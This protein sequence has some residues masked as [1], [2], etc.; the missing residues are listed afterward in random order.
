MS[1]LLTQL[2][3]GPVT[4]TY[5]GTGGLV[6]GGTAAVSKSK[7][8]L[9]TGGLVLGGAAALA[10]TKTITA[11]GGLVFNS[12]AATEYVSAIPPA[13]PEPTTSGAE[14][15]APRRM[16]VFRPR[17]GLAFGGAGICGMRRTFVAAVQRPTFNV[18]RST[19]SGTAAVCRSYCAPISGKSAFRVPRSAFRTEF[20]P[21]CGEELAVVLALLQ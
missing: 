19:F 4:Y 13:P 5:T 6:L 18:Q 20:S 9:P 2:A 17:G 10:K 7:D 1:L 21:D 8:F 15:Y 3:G 16:H 14:E 11:S 12:G